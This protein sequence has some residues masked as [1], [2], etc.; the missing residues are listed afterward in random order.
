MA[1]AAD[2]D[3][4]IPN[5][6]LGEMRRK[7]VENLEEEIR[8][9]VAITKKNRQTSPESKSCS[10]ETGDKDSS[11]I[12]QPWLEASPDELPLMQC[13]YCLRHA[14]GYC[15]KRGGRKADWREPLFLTL[16]D[17][18]RFRLEFDCKRCQMNVHT[19]PEGKEFERV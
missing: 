5:S 4:F 2:F 8:K 1:I 19:S 7:T 18:K 16:P 17:G 6:L 11:V 13:R 9:E 10:D 3:L 15:I 14:M 12:S